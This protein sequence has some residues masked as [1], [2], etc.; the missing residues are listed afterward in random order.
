MPP[1]S[2]WVEVAGM[3]H[4]QLVVSGIDSYTVE[5]IFT[6]IFRTLFWL[7][8]TNEWRHYLHCWTCWQQTC[9]DNCFLHLW[10]GLH[11]HWSAFQSLSEWWD[12]EW[13]TS[14][15]SMLVPLHLNSCFTFLDT[16]LLPVL[17]WLLWPMEWLATI[18]VLLVWDQWILWPL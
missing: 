18:W 1:G 5:C 16:Q 3:G 7:T 14:N 11:S 15:L 17:T 2:V 4:L 10:H 12:L 13:V 6:I 8:T 9:Y